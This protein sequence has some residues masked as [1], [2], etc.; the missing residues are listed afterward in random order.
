[1]ASQLTG[2]GFFS[3]KEGSLLEDGV[4]P[5]L[6]GSGRNTAHSLLKDDQ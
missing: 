2:V 4:W 1:M 6:D 5:E 3:C